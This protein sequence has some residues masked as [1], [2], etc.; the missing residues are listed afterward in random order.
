MWT[1]Y[2]AQSAPV[3]GTTQMPLW[4]A[5]NWASL[6]SHKVKNSSLSLLVDLTHVLTISIYMHS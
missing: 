4:S 6:M 5:G 2:G 1:E 3:S